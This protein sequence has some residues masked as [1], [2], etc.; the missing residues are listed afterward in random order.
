M[1]VVESYISQVESAVRCSQSLYRSFRDFSRLLC[2]RDGGLGLGL[3]YYIN[4]VPVCNAV[5]HG[6]IYGSRIHI[7]SFTDAISASFLSRPWKIV[8]SLISICASG[9]CAVQCADMDYNGKT[10]TCGCW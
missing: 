9:V 6:C 5:G 4:M 8:L 1:S 10:I 7:L 2:R 3:G